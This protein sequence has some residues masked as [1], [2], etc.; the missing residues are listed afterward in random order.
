MLIL[1]KIN[2]NTIEYNHK[3][4]LLFLCTSKTKVIM[5]TFFNLALF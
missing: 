3:Y 2:H 1:V 4:F 5:C